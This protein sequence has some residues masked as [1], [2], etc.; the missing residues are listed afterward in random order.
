MER[1]GDIL[2]AVRRV[3]AGERAGS[4]SAGAILASSFDFCGYSIFEALFSLSVRKREGA[5]K[6]RSLKA[7]KGRGVAAKNG[8]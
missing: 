5:E 1:G 6:P 4:I 2:V 3:A 8:V 7:A